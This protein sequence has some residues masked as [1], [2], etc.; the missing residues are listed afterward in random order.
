MERE[1]KIF[2]WSKKIVKE[3]FGIFLHF[4]SKYKKK[5]NH[6]IDH[7]TIKN[8]LKFLKHKSFAEI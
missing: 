4:F 8:F 2:Y 1:N 7:S 6:Y 5:W 3:Y